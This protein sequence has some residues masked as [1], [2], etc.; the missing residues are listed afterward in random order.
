MHPGITG[1]SGISEGLWLIQ[2]WHDT[3]T[4][5]RV[6]PRKVWTIFVHR[7]SAEASVRLICPTQMIFGTHSAERGL[8]E[9]VTQ[10]GSP[11]PAGRCFWH[12]SCWFF[13]LN[14]FWIVRTFF[15]STC[16][17]WIKRASRGPCRRMLSVG[18]PSPTARRMESR[19]SGD[20][21]P[22]TS[23]SLGPVLVFSMLAVIVSCHGA[24]KHRVPSPSEVNV[25]L[26]PGG[27]WL[28]SG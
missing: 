23:W 12:P 14:L 10:R 4:W 25:R 18:L 13:Y 7:W 21:K 28:I 26:L 16:K 24:C 6:T 22:S 5:I 1:I 11:A 8:G 19:I 27:L 3:Q 20:G 15:N 2:L 9:P 17:R